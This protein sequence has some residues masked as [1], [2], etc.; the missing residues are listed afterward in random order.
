MLE[1]VPGG[2]AEDGQAIWT[3]EALT[4][5]GVELSKRA[6]EIERRELELEELTRGTELLDRLASSQPDRNDSSALRPATP[7]ARVQLSRLLK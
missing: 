3:R 7:R 2:A 5:L 4:A 1:P 6:A